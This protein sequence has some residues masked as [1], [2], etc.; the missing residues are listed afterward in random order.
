MSGLTIYGDHRSGNC[1]K[2][3]WLA[4]DLGLEAIWKDVDVFGGETRTEAFL[5]LNPAGQVPVVQFADGR[6]LAQSNAIL[7]HLA[8][9]HGSR[10]LPKD[11][12]QRA[13]VYEWLFW[14]Q[15]SHEPC[16]AVARADRRW[17]GKTELDPE[18]E[19]RGRRALGRLEFALLGSD[20]LVGDCISLADLSLIAY[21]R[22]AHEGGFDL[23]PFPNLGHWIGRVESELKLDP[24]EDAA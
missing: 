24:I 18:M 14:E 3:L 19:A 16:I 20:Y 2:V 6:T 13:K 4:Q 15:Y 10:L 11:P 8:E 9:A 23:S 21:T 1:Q 12:A 5:Q 7:L 17:R 22:V